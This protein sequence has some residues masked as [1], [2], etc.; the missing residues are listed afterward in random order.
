V[1]VV[2]NRLFH[3]RGSRSF[4]RASFSIFLA[5]GLGGFLRFASYP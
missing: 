2:R 1:A 5:G 3:P 4:S